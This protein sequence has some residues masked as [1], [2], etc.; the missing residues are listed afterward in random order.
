MRYSPIRRSQ[1]IA[2]FGVGAMFTAP[3]G[4][5]M[6]TGGLDGWFDNAAHPGLEI[7][8]FRIGEWRLE[9]TLRVKELR[10]PPDYRQSRRGQD[11]T[12]NLDLGVPALLF[13]L[14][15]FCPS[16]SCR[17]L[18]ERRPHHGRRAR[19][20]LCEAKSASA[21]KGKKQRTAPFVAQVPFIAM[22]AD[23]HL[24]DFPW[25]EW[26][27]RSANPNCERQM[28]LRSTG[29]ATLASQTV[30]CD[31]GVEPRSLAQ[32]TEASERNGEPA[33]F[34]TSTLERDSETRYLCRGRRPWVDDRYGE[35][36]ELP[37]QGGLRSSTAA[38]YAHVASAI[39][40][41]GGASGLPDGLIEALDHPPL[42]YKIDT[43]RQ[44][45]AVT[46][47]NVRK[48]DSQGQVRSFSDEDLGRAIDSFNAAKEGAEV[49]DTDFEIESAA[50]KL[51]RPEYAIL[52]EAMKSDDLLVRPQDM[53]LFDEGLSKIFSRVNLV[54]NLRE[55]RVMYG[56]SRIQPN[57]DRP[58]S[59]MKS[60]MWNS[61]P[62]YF[63]SWLPAYVVHGEGLF[64]EFSE[65]VL[66]AWESRPDVQQRVALLATNPRRA[67]AQAGLEDPA[68]VPRFVLLHTFAHLLINQLVFECGYSS[69]S[70]RE[71]LFVA[72]GLNPMAG[73]MIY[74]AAGD[75]EGTMGGLV[76]MGKPGKLEPALIASLERARWCSADPVCMELGAKGQGPHSMNLAACHACGLL[77]ETACEVFNTMLDRA[78][79]TGSHSDPS[80]G[81]FASFAEQVGV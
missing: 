15:H 69:A 35:G 81:F 59:Q 48:A 26:V 17:A 65:S 60:Q 20:R 75:S 31:C 10:L 58:L 28:Y 45:G 14:W 62:Q 12:P 79:V 57:L 37:I 54:E 51:R 27:H 53:A 33:T 1:L 76:R 13:P 64:F 32:I 40:L 41:P 77:P 42:K 55:T 44:L 73:V 25:R 23:G 49:D 2:P 80:L 18:I 39:Y 19:C 61:E 50:E 52:R 30:H 70:L 67:R 22:C 4:T 34:L 71:R 29:G 46:I 43:L 21:A 7:E 9:E 72:R 47:E 11:P 63:E 68:L 74:T 6:I 36:C 66:T 5:G 56:F 3:D 8:E 16:P 24:Q 78:L 38:Y